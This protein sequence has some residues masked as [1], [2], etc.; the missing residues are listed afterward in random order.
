MGERECPEYR[1]LANKNQELEQKVKSLNQE[2]ESLNEV[3]AEGKQKIDDTTKKVM[4]LEVSTVFC[5]MGS[6]SFLVYSYYLFFFLQ[7][8]K[9]ELIAE[10][11]KGLCYHYCFY[12]FQL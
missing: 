8:T 1:E 2:V 5:A 6:Y 9:T 12:I 7:R 10:I 3:I 4:D 11:N